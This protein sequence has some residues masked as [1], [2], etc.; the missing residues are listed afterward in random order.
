[1]SHTTTVHLD[2]REQQE[3]LAAI[4]AQLGLFVLRGVGAGRTGSVSQLCRA[5]ADRRMVVVKK[6]VENVTPD[7]PKNT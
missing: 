6:D 7:T 5:I 3:Q 4:A 2:N 1:M